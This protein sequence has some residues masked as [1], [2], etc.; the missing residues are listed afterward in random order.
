MTSSPLETAPRRPGIG[1][2]LT[3]LVITT[4]A[5][6][7]GA[8]ASRTSAQFYALLDKP[9]WAPPAWLFGPVWSLLYLMMAVAAWRVWR[10]AGFRGA[11]RAL[12]LYVVQ[13]GF[14]AL[15]TWL[16]FVWRNGPWATAEV[17]ALWALIVATLL[18]FRQ[19]DRPAAVLLAPYLAWVSFASA[20]TIA[21][22]QR[23]PGLL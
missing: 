9:V 8:L 18:A 19:H 10:A 12:A 4:V 21:V 23:N 6:G 1:A 17:L 13:L 5:A 14:N 22:W 3:C 11:R 20:L 2:L 15:W 7:S 16:F